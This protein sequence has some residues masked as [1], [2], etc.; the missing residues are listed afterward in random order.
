MGTSGEGA[1]GS[2]SSSNVVGEKLWKACVPGKVKIF[3]WRACLDSLPTRSNL[4]KR[5]VMNEELCVVCGGQV[6]S[7]EHVLCDCNVARAVWFQSLGVRMDAD[8]RVSLMIWLANLHLQGSQSGF[9]LCLMLIWNLWKHRNDIL[10]NGKS[11]P[12][13]EIVLYVERWQQEFHR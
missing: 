12:P 5:R 4:C 13:L 8:Q 1:V 11:V 2:S 7:I 3:V 6:E 9:E 10:W